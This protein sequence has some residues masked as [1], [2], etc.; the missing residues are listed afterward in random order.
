MHLAFLVEMEM[1]K[2]VIT[3]ASGTALVFMTV[4]AL[5]ANWDFSSVKGFLLSASNGPIFPGVHAFSV[6]AVVLATYWLMHITGSLPFGVVLGLATVAIHELIWQ[7]FGLFIHD[8]TVINLYP[9][10]Y[11]AIL[12]LALRPQTR[13]R[14]FLLSI[15]LIDIAFYDAFLFAG[16]IPWHSVTYDPLNI[17]S[18]ILPC[19]VWAL[20]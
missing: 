2:E 7:S 18:W 9:I 17:V 8:Y 11:V 4:N 15:A 14:M 13:F 6:I 16:I 3:A 10:F 5:W 19:S 1:K 20:A 12:I